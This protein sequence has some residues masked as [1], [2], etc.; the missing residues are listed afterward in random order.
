MHGTMDNV[1]ATPQIFSL[2]HY[3]YRRF[4]DYRL[5]LWWLGGPFTCIVLGILE[6]SLSFDNAVLNASILRKMSPFWQKMF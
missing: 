4:I 2:D 6:V 1:Y 5:F 3:C